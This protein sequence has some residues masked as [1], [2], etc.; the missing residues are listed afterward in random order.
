MQY[1]FFFQ[2]LGASGSCD[3]VFSC[4]KLNCYFICI[5]FTQNFL[6]FC[7]DLSLQIS[8]LPKVGAVT[9]L[10]ERISLMESIRSICCLEHNTCGLTLLHVVKV[11]GVL[12]AILRISFSSSAINLIISNHIESFLTA[13]QSCFCRRSSSITVIILII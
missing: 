5:S 8:F 11:E 12:K 13:I 7:L 2:N 6:S 10:I 3:I 1:V 4:I 9:N